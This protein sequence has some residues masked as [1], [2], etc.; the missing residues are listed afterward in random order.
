[1]MRKGGDDGLRTVECLRGRLLA[2]RVASKAAKEQADN[3]AKRLEELERKLAEEIKYRNMA[4]K[5]LKHALRKLESLRILD[6]AGQMDL[7]GS[8]AS[9]SSS[10]CFSDHQKLE[11]WGTGSPTVDSEQ[12]DS[13]DEVTGAP[14]PSGSEDLLRDDVSGGSLVDSPHHHD[15]SWSSVGTAQSRNEGESH[16]DESNK[17]GSPQH[18]TAD[19][20]RQSSAD[21]NKQDTVEHQVEEVDNTLALVPAS[22]EPNLEG[23]KP[24][25]TNNVQSVLLALRHVKEQLQ[26]SMGRTGVCS[27]KQLYGR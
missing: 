5:R 17:G 8:L 14:S 22:M 10:H 1:M 11:G 24:V 27:S 15:G 25:V 20:A 12:R 7:H 21:D 19:A 3:M 13:Q 26:Y 2:E 9:S 6:V 4:E 18:W 23:C 16:G